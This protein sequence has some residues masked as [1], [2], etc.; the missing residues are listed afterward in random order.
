MIR[1]EAM[2]LSAGQAAS[3]PMAVFYR[4]EGD[5]KQMSYQ[6]T[7][8]QDPNVS[9]SISIDLKVPVG[10]EGNF[11]QEATFVTN[12]RVSRETV[13]ATYSDQIARVLLSLIDA[14]AGVTIMGLLSAASLEAFQALVADPACSL[15]TEIKDVIAAWNASEP[16]DVESWQSLKA[17]MNDPLLIVN[18]LVVAIYASDDPGVTLEALKGATDLAAYKE[19]VANSNLSTDIKDY[20]ATLTDDDWAAVETETDAPKG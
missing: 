17:T 5:N 19:L 20:V 6:W 9:Y 7:S 1:N 4:V 12:T 11:T 15:P 14:T 8:S 13:V 2:R 16:E 18:T 10:E 3:D